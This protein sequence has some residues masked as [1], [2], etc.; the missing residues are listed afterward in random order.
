MWRYALYVLIALAAFSAASVAAAYLYGR[1]AEGAQGPE[2]WALP[3]DGAMTRLDEHVEALTSRHLQQ[4]GLA[5]ISSNLDAFAARGLSARVAGRSLDLMYYIWKNDLS[6]RLLM[7]EVIAAADR[8]VRVRL[9][10]D[11]VGVELK[12]EV[13]LGLASHANIELRLFNPTR[14]RPGTWRG[15]PRGPR[16]RRRL[17][18][19]R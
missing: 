8:G 15:N 12:D 9:L 16:G 17:R 10:L 19:N 4:S 3:R 1:F 7:S 2:S 6:G 11:D 13:Y 18:R 5:L 14:A